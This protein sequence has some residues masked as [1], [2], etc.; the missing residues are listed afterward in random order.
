MGRWY[1][2]TDI[3]N[4]GASVRGGGFSTGASTG[5]YTLVLASDETASVE[6]GFRC[7]YRP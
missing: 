7:V 4:I 2:L 6:V 5:I 3:G 1:G